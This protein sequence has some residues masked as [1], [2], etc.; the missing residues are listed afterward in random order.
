MLLEAL[1]RR[2]LRPHLEQLGAT[3]QR[4]ELAA[5][6]SAATL[7]A[8]SAE[9]AAIF[10]ATGSGGPGLC[11]AGFGRTSALRGI[12]AGAGAGTPERAAPVATVLRGWLGADDDV[13]T[14]ERL[15]FQER[16]EATAPMSTIA[17]SKDSS[18]NTRCLRE[19]RMR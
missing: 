7:A 4:V 6:R 13:S 16:N 5:A 9:A 14:S 8:L 15:P 18:K 17:S 1:A 10:S 19:S 11:A 12:V 3:V 2:A